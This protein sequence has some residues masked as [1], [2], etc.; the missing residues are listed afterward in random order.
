MDEKVYEPGFV[1][2]EKQKA[3]KARIGWCLTLPTLGSEADNK[4]SF[5]QQI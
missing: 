5:F 3:P 1:R 4:P 2:T